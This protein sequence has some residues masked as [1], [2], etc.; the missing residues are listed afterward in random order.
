MY[1]SICVGILQCFVVFD[2]LM[3]NDTNYANHPL[4]DR[5]EQLKKYVYTPVYTVHVCMLHVHFVRLCIVTAYLYTCRSTARWIRAHIHLSCLFIDI[6]LHGFM[7]IHDRLYM[8][9]AIS[10]LHVFWVCTC[11][12]VCVQP[13]TIICKTYKCMAHYI[14]R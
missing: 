14:A 5:A 1:I 3:V 6:G 7:C 12:M 8:Y 11:T 10:T 4:R 9:L 13:L 2:V